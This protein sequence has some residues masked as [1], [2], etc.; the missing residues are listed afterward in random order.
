MKNFKSLILA[1]CLSGFSTFAGG[2]EALSPRERNQKLVLNQL[3]STFQFPK[4]LIGHMTEKSV[5]VEFKVLENHKLEVT[6]I[7]C[8]DAFLVLHLRKQLE[9]TKIYLPQGDFEREFKLKLIF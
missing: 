6:N 1:L 2:E 7:D 4:E 3:E 8:N 5:L 9:Q